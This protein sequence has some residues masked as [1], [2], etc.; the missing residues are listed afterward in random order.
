MI[1]TD[2]SGFV[3]PMQEG[4][5]ETGSQIPRALARGI[6]RTIRTNPSKTGLNPLSNHIDIK[7][8][9]GIIHPFPHFNVGLV[10]PAMG[11]EHG[12]VTH[13]TEKYRKQ[14]LIH[15]LI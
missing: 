1:K 2:L 13:P 8:S 12:I 14:L 6:W 15:A 9:Y 4:A 10:E 3:V 11:F 7:L 5:C